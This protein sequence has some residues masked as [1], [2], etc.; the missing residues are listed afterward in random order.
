MVESP[1]M[2]EMLLIPANRNYMK[3]LSASI[4][5]ARPLSPVTV[6]LLPFCLY[7][8]DLTVSFLMPTLGCRWFPLVTVFSCNSHN[9]Q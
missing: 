2:Q 5:K 3:P 7:N 4:T 8:L 6:N 1:K 9:C